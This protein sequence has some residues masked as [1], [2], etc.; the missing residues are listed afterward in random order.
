M[1]YAVIYVKELLIMTLQ[2][3]V[4]LILASNKA[5]LVHLRMFSFFTIAILDGVQTFQIQFIID[6]TQGPFL[7]N[8]VH[9]GPVISK[10]M[11]K[12]FK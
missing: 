10:G 7:S 8:L 11:K 5:A 3:T 4:D 9:I 12:K 1:L 6:T 2:L